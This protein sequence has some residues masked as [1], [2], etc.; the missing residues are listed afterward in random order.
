MG[1]E[2]TLEAWEAPVLPLNYA[3]YGEKALIEMWSER[4]GIKPA[5]V[6]WKA[7][8]LSLNYARNMRGEM[9]LTRSNI[10]CHLF[11]AT[12]TIITKNK[13]LSTAALIL[14]LV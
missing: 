11:S 12:T 5:L 4:R 13:V 7:T 14:C 3:R 1:I 6:T 10:Q 9:I 8:V 2:P